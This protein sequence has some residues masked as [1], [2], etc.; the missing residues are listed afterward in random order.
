MK[1]SSIFVGSLSLF[2]LLSA[3]S[4]IDSLKPFD[5]Q[6]AA[7]LMQQRGA[8]TP[9][10]QMVS[11]SLPQK[12]AWKKTRFTP[13][14]TSALVVLVPKQQT[15]AD[16][17]ESIQARVLPYEYTPDVTAKKYVDAEIAYA[18]KNCRQTEASLLRDTAQEVIYRMKMIQ[19]H[20]SQDQWQIG[21]VFNGVDGVY[22]VRYVGDA[23]SISE[24]HFMQMAQVISTATLVGDPRAGL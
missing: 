17:S 24:K 12:E 19:C 20:N 21:K 22:S 7:I 8:A 13:D 14:E 4:P 2:S 10:K 9:S 3:C 23:G 18:R 6:Q 16:F 11:L 15:P 1:K 5:Q